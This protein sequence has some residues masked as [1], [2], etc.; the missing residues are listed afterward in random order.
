MALAEPVVVGIKEFKPER[1][2][3]KSLL[4]ASIGTWVL[5]MS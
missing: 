3:R 4:K 2:R 1:A 5:V